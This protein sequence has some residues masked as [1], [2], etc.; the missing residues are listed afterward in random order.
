MNKVNKKLKKFSGTILVSKNNELII[1]KSYGYKDIEGKVKNDIDTR[2]CIGSISKIF[3]AI[4]II[5]LH[6][7]EKLDIDE[8]VKKYLKIE[9]LEEDLKIKHLLSHT[10][11]L[12]NFVLCRKEINLYED[13]KAED[14]AKKV[15]H[16]KRNYKNGDKL[17][18]NN[19]GYLILALIIEEVSKMK[20]Q[21]Y[22]GKN[23]FL[24]LDMKDSSFLSMDRKNIA[25]GYRKNNLSKQLDESV[26][27]GCGDIVSTSIDL[28]KFIL[29]IN[30]GKIISK[31]SFDEMKKIHGKNIFLKYGYGL[32]L[33]NKSGIN[34][35]G[36]SGSIPNS[37]AS[38]ISYYEK[39]EIL[40]I[41]LS[42]NIKNIKFYIPSIMSVQYIEKYLYK[43]SV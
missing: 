22:I 19:T 18:Y 13:N 12:K 35:F 29:G 1:N 23:I 20:F 42:N 21:D 31:A 43:I 41:V 4:A 25:N 40:I 14:I 26:F 10:S 27:F 16:M 9:G 17:S 7:E 24:K 33:K 15:I 39:E 34:S 37:Y 5:K 38:K 2:F 28:N 3:T 6:E 32:M 30:S 36:H 8:S 11:G